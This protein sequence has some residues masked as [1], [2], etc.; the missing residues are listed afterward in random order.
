[1]GHTYLGE[2]EQIVLLAVWRLGDEGYGMRIRQ[3][4]E[5]RTGRGV[6][7]GAVYATLER[8]AQKGCVRT[9]IGEP[10]AARGGRAKRYYTI[11]RT[12]VAALDDARTQLAR[13]WQGL[14]RRS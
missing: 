4:I 6:T 11:T 3:E 1:M 12:G 5:A 2:F 9:S 13:M 10:T 14:P 8:L 7:I